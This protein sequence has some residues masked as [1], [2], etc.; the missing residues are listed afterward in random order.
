MLIIRSSRQIYLIPLLCLLFHI[1]QAPAQYQSIELMSGYA[2]N[3]RSPLLIQQSG[4]DNHVL[5]ADYKTDSF[6]DI[7]YFLLRFNFYFYKR[8]LEIQFLH[9]KISL[10]SPQGVV[11]QFK[12]N[13]GFN[14]ISLHY[15]LVLD[16]VHLRFGIGA[17]IAY[18]ESIVSGH[19]FSGSGGLINS[20]YYLAGPALLV[21]ANKEFPLS[22]KI[23]LNT[24]VQLTAAWA[25]VPIATGQAYA[26]NFALHFLLGGGYK[27]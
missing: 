12:I 13:N 7:P 24:E 16:L 14:V 19:S 21:G 6:R 3:L 22:Q 2:C 11:Q 5:R 23:Y 1:E 9:H 26:S 25:L 27:F 10:T 18:P 15:R 20:G 17:I 4:Q 8:A